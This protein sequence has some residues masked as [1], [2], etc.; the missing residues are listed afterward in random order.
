MSLPRFPHYIDGA[1][2]EAAATFES[3]DPFTE[4]AWAEMPAAS[5]NSIIAMRSRMRVRLSAAMS[6]MSGE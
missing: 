5:A 4:E 6:E 2:V 1:F 3:L